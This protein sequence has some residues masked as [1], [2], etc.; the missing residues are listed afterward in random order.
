M[1][2]NGT[3]KLSTKKRQLT[4][5]SFSVKK[6]TSRQKKSK[7]TNSS[8]FIVDGLTPII[9]YPR[10]IEN[11]SYTTAPASGPGRHRSMD[12]KGL[13]LQ[14]IEESYPPLVCPVCFQTSVGRAEADMHLKSKHHG[15]KVFK[16]VAPNCNQA[17]SSK[18]GL[19]YHLEHV[20]QVSRTND[21]R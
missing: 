2:R 4:D 10:L 17:Y 21:N 1:N 5:A 7:T 12:V 11:K 16:C 6:D 9:P 15:Q 20:H 3:A 19:R 18:P 14:L 8:H 13:I